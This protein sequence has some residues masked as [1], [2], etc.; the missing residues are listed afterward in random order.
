MTNVSFCFITLLVFHILRFHFQSIQIHV[1]I[2]ILISSWIQVLFR[3]MVHSQIRLSR[4]L[5]FML[6]SI[7]GECKI[8]ALTYII[9]LHYIGTCHLAQ[10][11]A[12]IVFLQC[13]VLRKDMRCI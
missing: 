7:P 9:L 3:N 10:N 1:P 4:D 5:L 11:I 8:H 2:S 12:Y 13:L 6:N